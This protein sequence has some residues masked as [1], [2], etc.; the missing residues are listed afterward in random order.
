MRKVVF[1]FVGLKNSVS[2]FFTQNQVFGREVT[3]LWLREVYFLR[4]VP[5]PKV[6]SEASSCFVAELFL[7]MV[8]TYDMVIYSSGRKKN[9]FSFT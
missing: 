1:L 2:F 3:I 8:Y 5:N 4:E 7:L 6:L 9:L